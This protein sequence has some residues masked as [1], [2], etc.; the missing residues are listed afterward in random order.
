MTMS[1]DNTWSSPL[2]VILLKKE[3]SQQSH[4]VKITKLPYGLQASEIHLNEYKTRSS[5]LVSF[6]NFPQGISYGSGKL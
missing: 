1:Q 4:P 2:R 5:L 3:K 6:G